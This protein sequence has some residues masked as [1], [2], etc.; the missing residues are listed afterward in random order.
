MS[1]ETSIIIF[2]IIISYYISETI[3]Y[4]KKWK[5]YLVCNIGT[6]I[7]RVFMKT[8]SNLSKCDILS[9]TVIKIYNSVMCIEHRIFV[10]RLFTLRV[11]F[12]AHYITKRD[13]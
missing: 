7:K 13:Y 12:Y 10:L 5:R 8:T 1:N 9:L 6:G 2:R 4:V 11:I 3:F